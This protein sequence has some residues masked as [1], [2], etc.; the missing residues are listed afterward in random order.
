[1]YRTE[2]YLINRKLHLFD[3]DCLIMVNPNS[4]KS[5]HFER[6]YAIKQTMLKYKHYMFSVFL[7]VIMASSKFMLS[8]LFIVSGV[9]VQRTWK[10][11][12][13]SIC[14]ATIAKV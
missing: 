5:F 11:A 12:V 1:M 9:C 13:S 2:L 8:I 3:T 6:N 7:Y 4:L 14:L 10:T